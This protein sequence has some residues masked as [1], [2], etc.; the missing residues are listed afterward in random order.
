[1]KL[2]MAESNAHA[3]AL[4]RS[5]IGVRRRFVFG[6]RRRTAFRRNLRILWIF[7]LDL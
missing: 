5:R 2:L 3:G 1:M 6:P 4:E 7:N